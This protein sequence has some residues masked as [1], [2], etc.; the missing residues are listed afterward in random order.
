MEMTETSAKREAEPLDPMVLLKPLKA[1]KKVDFTTRLPDDW[2]GMAG[3]IAEAFNEAVSNNENMAKEFSQLVKTVGSYG[4]IRERAKVGPLGGGWADCMNSVYTLMDDLARPI[5]EVGEVI[6]AVA[7]G[8]LTQIMELEVEGERRKGAF[9]HT[10]KTVNSMVERLGSFASEVTR[11]AKAVGTD[12]KL[13]DQADVPDVSGIWKDLTDNVN[14][15]G[16]AFQNIGDIL[17]GTPQQPVH[18]EVDKL[19]QMFDG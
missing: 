15:I 1:F 19:T 14:T 5:S 13:G 8:D 11:V 17:A 12:G 6:G 3:E 18:S 16:E 9:L 10:A 7:K 4:K 2:P